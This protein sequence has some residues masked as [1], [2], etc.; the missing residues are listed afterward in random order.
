MS[1]QITQLRCFVAVAAQLHFGRAAAS[2]N[3]SQPPLTRHVQLL[4]HTLG[5]LL[6]ERNK[7]SVKLT[8][9]GRALLPE[10]TDILRRLANAELAAKRAAEGAQGSVV[11]GFI[12]ASSYQVL[13]AFVTLAK[14]HLPGIELVLREMQ[15]LDQ[16]E[17]LSS[18][19]IDLALVRPVTQRPEISSLQVLR[20]RFVL[21]IP[22]SHSL[23]S[24]RNPTIRDLDDEPFIMYSP[25]EGRYSYELLKGVFR[26]AGCSPRYVNYITYPHSMLSL[27]SA[28]LGMALVPVS[29][30][31]LRLDRIH[32]A[33]ID[34]GN[35]EAELHMAWRAKDTEPAIHNLVD[36]MKRYARLRSRHQATRDLCDDVCRSDSALQD[37]ECEGD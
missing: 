17:A 6:F 35:V 31:R 11:M 1:V 21:A 26:M 23:A 19:Q 33:E 32:Y 36:L 29:A 7:R 4:E 28:G 34:V 5:V 13:P 37:L 3:M 18:N 27:V 14:E 12:P 9:S 20:E 22:T 16:Y 2:L 8:P 10:A 25:L 24:N 30:T 15:S